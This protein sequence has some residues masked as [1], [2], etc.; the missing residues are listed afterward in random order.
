[1]HRRTGVRSTVQPD[2]VQRR[3]HDV[4]RVLSLR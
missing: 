4:L 2:T 1:M 3:D